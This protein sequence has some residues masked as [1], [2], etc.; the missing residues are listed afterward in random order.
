[1]ILISLEPTALVVGRESFRS[2]E[3]TALGVGRE[4]FRLLEPTALAS[5][6]ESFRLLEPTSL[7]VGRETFNEEGVSKGKISFK[8]TSCIFVPSSW[9]S[10]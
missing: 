3:P 7:G 6:G 8:I 5:E 1:M 10:V 2:L 4:S 9:I